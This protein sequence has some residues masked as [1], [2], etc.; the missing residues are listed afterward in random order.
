MNMH[1]W[2]LATCCVAVL[3]FVGCDNPGNDRSPPDADNTATNANDMHDDDVDNDGRTV[4]ALTPLDQ[5]NES[6]DVE[7]TAAIRAD[8]LEIDDLSTDARNVKII[9]TEGGR[10]TLRGP[11]ETEAERAAIL[12]V[13]KTHAGADRVDDQMSIAKD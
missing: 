8:V 1:A 12:E 9:T 13:A 11:V 6:E 7:L 4:D 10:V 2:C 5:S 3:A